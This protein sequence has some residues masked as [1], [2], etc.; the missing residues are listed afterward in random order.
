MSA[1]DAAL[2]NLARVL[3]VSVERQRGGRWQP[4]PLPRASDEPVSTP[5]RKISLDPHRDD[6]D[7]PV[8]VDHHRA[9]NAA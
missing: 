2:A 8:T 1:R 4:S 9:D 5:A 3:A 6:V 7:I